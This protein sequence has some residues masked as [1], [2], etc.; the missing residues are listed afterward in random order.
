MCDLA[1][2][3]DVTTSKRLGVLLRYTYINFR[4]EVIASDGRS[5]ELD[6]GHRAELFRRH[7]VLRKEGIGQ[8]V[9]EN[10]LVVWGQSGAPKLG[11]VSCRSPD[12]GLVDLKVVTNRA[13]DILEDRRGF[14]EL[15]DS[16]YE[17]AVI[18]IPHVKF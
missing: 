15:M 10:A 17:R 13:A 3:A 8:R 18:N 6:T 9:V 7:V 14:E 4:D 1:S 5:E 2:A 12:F 16:A 11:R